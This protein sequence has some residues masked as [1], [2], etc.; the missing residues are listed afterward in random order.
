[1]TQ[2]L[3]EK[4]E[5]RR[6][7]RL[8]QKAGQTVTPKAKKRRSKKRRGAGASPEHKDN[9]IQGALDAV[10]NPTLPTKDR[11]LFVSAT[12]LSDWLRCR[13]K[14][15]W[16]HTLRLEPSVKPPA[17]A[18]GSL[19]H[20]VLDEYYQLPSKKRMIIA[21]ERIVKKMLKKVSYESL[22]K[23]DLELLKAMCVGYAEW[24][25]P[26][27]AQLGVRKVT[28]EKWFE[29]PLDDEGTIIVRG[30]LDTL[31]LTHKKQVVNLMEH[32]FKSQIRIDSL[33]LNYQLSVYLWA[34]RKEFPNAKDY[35]AHYN[36]LRKQMPGPRVKAALF[37]REPVERDDAAIEM[38]RQDA[39]R[40]VKDMFTGG[41][42]P[43]P[44]DSCAWSCDFTGPCLLRGRPADVRE[45]L[46]RDFKAKEYTG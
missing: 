14:Y 36:V 7:R 38:W 22:S 21:M 2:T 15:H 46:N 33:D 25:N 35:R 3:E 6:K 28:P 4:R 26:L 19:G 17:F 31:F 27:D 1:M 39:I 29:H 45:V 30:R 18:M 9:V 24:A 42:Y 43:N 34:A 13:L 12:K 11:P 8:A 10:I 41:I 5:R 23:D 16:R 20:K 40:V 44:M 37:H 32:K